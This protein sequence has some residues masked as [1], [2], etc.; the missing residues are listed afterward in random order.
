MQPGE[1][2]SLLNRCVYNDDVERRITSQLGAQFAMISSSPKARH[3]SPFSVKAPDDGDRVGNRNRDR[4]RKTPTRRPSSQGRS[5]REF[6][7]ELLDLRWVRT[8]SPLDR[9]V[10]FRLSFRPDTLSDPIAVQPEPK[11][12]APQ[13]R[14]PE[15]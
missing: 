4:C 15:V 7:C 8:T 10:S 3:E 2:A 11:G 1:Y 5:S 12:Q 13:E 6:C 9:D 14:L